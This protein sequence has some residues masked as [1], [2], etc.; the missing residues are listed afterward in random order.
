[1][2]I[3]SYVV[4][5]DASLQLYQ[6][7]QKQKGAGLACLESNLATTQGQFLAF[8]R[9]AGLES[10]FTPGRLTTVRQLL[11]QAISGI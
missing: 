10:P 9:E 2:Y 7:E 1:M 6:L 4:S 3:I 5:N 11:E 8:I